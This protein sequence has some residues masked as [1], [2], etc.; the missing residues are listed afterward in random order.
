M[1]K[2][3]STLAAVP[4]F[5]GYIRVSQR[6][7]REGDSFISPA[8]QREQIEGWAKL[9]GVT[10]AEWHTDIDE[11]GGKMDR[12]AFN[13]T[14]ARVESGAIAGIAVAKVDRLG[15]T[16]I[17][18]LEAGAEIDAAGGELASVA[19][20]IDPT[21]PVG[22]MLFRF[23]LVLAEFELDRIRE[24]WRVSRQKAVERG[25]HIAS[26][27]PTG[28]TRGEDGRLEV[29]PDWGAAVTE[30]F[31]RRADGA[32]WG[33]LAEYFNDLGVVGPYEAIFWTTGSLRHVVA[34][35]VYLG[36]AYHGEFVNHDAHPPLIDRETWERAQSAPQAAW[37]GESPAVLTGLLRCAGCR[38][39]MKADN[40]NDRG[41]KR[42][43]YRCR[44]RHSTGEC[45][46]PASIL[47]HKVEPFVE[48]QFLE[49]FGAR[50]AYSSVDSRE[51]DAAIAALELS[52]AELA[53]YRDDERIVGALG[54][55]AFVKGLQ[56]RAGKV[57]TARMAVAELQR[58][59]PASGI[60]IAEDLRALW[61][62]LGVDEKRRLLTAGLGAVFLRKGRLPVE[63]RVLILPLGSEPDDLPRRGRRRAVVSF[64][65]PD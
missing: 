42:R 47:A 28:Y 17:D 33:E 18:A 64:P 38:F 36:E 43:L 55:D 54:Q 1:T 63:D 9:R 11:T 32:S 52:E 20:G 22:K 4:L 15:R 65:W 12:P 58:L 57:E 39:V 8:V 62:E 13:L 40:M 7:G 61:P 16:L 35:R 19:E 24:S 10:I 44:K 29:D 23:F 41:T 34:K 56:V 26:R 37:T 25:V 14:K 31:K 49:F 6:R 46:A 3:D 2:R 27:P 50:E 45:P 51:I 53:A 5:D 48:A 21:T 60:P 30:L 59:S